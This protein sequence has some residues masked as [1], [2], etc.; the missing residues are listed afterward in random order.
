MTIRN[1]ADTYHRVRQQLPTVVII[2]GFVSSHQVGAAQ[3]SI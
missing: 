2:E 1:V 3:L